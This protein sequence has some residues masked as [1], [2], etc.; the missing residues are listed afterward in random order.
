M[1]STI[2]SKPA[3]MTPE[4]AEGDMAAF[5]SAADAL[6]AVLAGMTTFTG[7]L[8]PDVPVTIAWGTR[9]RMLPQR[10]MLRAKA[11]LPDARLV[12]LPGCGHVPMTDNP[13]LVADVLLS[14]SS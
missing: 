4:Q 14:G 1:Y 6:N 2:V 13:A 8:P 12:R 10:Q 3:R 11:S 5:V 7:H 9:D